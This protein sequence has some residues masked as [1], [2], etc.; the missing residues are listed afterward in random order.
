MWTVLKKFAEGAKANAVVFSFFRDGCC[1][2][3]LL[4][5]AA[6][7]EGGCKFPKS[8]KELGVFCMLGVTGMWGNQLFYILGLYY[9]SATVASC[10]Q[11]AI[12][13]FAAFFAIILRVEPFPPLAKFRGW[14]KLL[15]I[16]C[17]AG[18]ALVLTLGKPDH[19]A[20]SAE[21]KKAS[22]GNIFLLL[23]CSCMAL[24]INIQKV[25]IFR[26]DKEPGAVGSIW[27][28]N[29]VHI[30]AWS[31]FFGAIAMIITALVGNALKVEFLGF[32]DQDPDPFHIP[33]PMFVGLVYAVFISSG[34]LLLETASRF[35]VV[36][37]LTRCC[38]CVCVCVCRG[39]GRL[40]TLL[41]PDH[42]CKQAPSRHGCDRILASPGPCRCD[43]RLLPYWNLPEGLRWL[44]GGRG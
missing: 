19:K 12:P 27:V 31:Y 8:A 40:S 4:I 33:K 39:A 7:L 34:E 30:T 35:S 41:R 23:N 43:P 15:G 5:A 2:P 36:P 22:I 29:P 6:L 3:V 13:V 38:V 20:S 44:R 32:G 11:P 16:L 14:L 9:T 17:A 18:G 21:A 24:Y 42:V 37:D 26:N 28:K 1:F 10:W 25:F